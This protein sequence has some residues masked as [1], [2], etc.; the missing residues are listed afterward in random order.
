M[1]V[2][3]ASVPMKNK[4]SHPK[5]NCW[6]LVVGFVGVVIGEGARVPVGAKNDA[7]LRLGMKHTDDVLPVDTLVVEQPCAELLHDDRVGKFVQFGGKPFGAGCMGG[8][9]RHTWSETSLFGHILISR[10]GVELWDDN[11]FLGFLL[12]VWV[13]GFWLSVAG[14]Q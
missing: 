4:P 1:I 9:F 11:R 6:L 7:L 14:N 3:R 8:R 13:G 2:Q 12:P 10:V 5:G